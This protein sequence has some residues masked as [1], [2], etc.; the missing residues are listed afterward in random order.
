MRVGGG[1]GE[2]V[3]VGDAD[4]HGVD[5]GVLG[6]RLVEVDFS[7]HIGYSDAV[8]I[9]TDSI[10]HASQQPPVGGFVGWAEPEGIE[11]GDGAGAHGEDVPDDTA[12]AGGCALQR[13]D[14]RR[15]VVGFDFEHHGQPVADVDG[16]GVFRTGL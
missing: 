14:G 8:A 2:L 11:Q 4:A 7:G 15:M 12:D 16:A 6:V 13:L 5:Q 3:N 1:T 9:P 10:D